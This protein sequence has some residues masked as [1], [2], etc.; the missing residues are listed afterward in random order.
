MN[1][2]NN[3][4]ALKVARPMN[5]TAGQEQQVTAGRGRGVNLQAN[6]TRREQLSRDNNSSSNNVNNIQKANIVC[7]DLQ[8]RD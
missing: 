3:S 6:K 2:T 8:P 5:A 4:S 1:S 7:V